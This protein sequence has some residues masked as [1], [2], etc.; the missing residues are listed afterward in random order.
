LLTFIAGAAISAVSIPASKGLARMQG[1]GLPE[2]VALGI[3]HTVPV[4]LLTALI[5]FVVP[6]FSHHKTVLSVAVLAVTGGIVGF[7]TGYFLDAFERLGPLVELF[8]GPL[9]PLT[10]GAFLGVLVGVM[11]GALGAVMLAVIGSTP[12][13]RPGPEGECGA[14]SRR[15]ARMLGAVAPAYFAEGVLLVALSLMV[16]AE[17]AGQ[18]RLAVVAG[19]A[20]VASVAA[21]WLAW[22]KM[23]E[24]ERRMTLD[25]YALTFVILFF[26]AAAWV[27]A[28]TLGWLP[29]PTLFEV[30]IA[31]NIAYFLIATGVTAM[32]MLERGRPAEVAP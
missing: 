1:L 3:A 15:D 23:D 24:W 31:V 6:R 25:A 17:P 26:A 22:A 19:L 30:F 4:L 29:D 12:R 21:L 27:G 32:A 5:A 16:V 28:V 13:I 2:P 7:V 20:L 11:L 10:D 18:Q 9:A 8:T 14:I